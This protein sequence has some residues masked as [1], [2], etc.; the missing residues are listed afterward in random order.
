M[1]M[2]SVMQARRAERSRLMSLVVLTW[3]AAVLAGAQVLAMVQKIRFQSGTIP[4]LNPLHELRRI[5]ELP[6]RKDK[7][8][9][10]LQQIPN[11]PED[12]AM[13][14]LPGYMVQ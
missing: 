6:N 7:P 13:V 1:N 4:W 12:P 10:G 14:F 9:P 8:S 5:L 3:Y 11:I 2:N